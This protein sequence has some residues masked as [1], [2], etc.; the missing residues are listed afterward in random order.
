MQLSMSGNAAKDK[1]SQLEAKRP[2]KSALK[3]LKPDG[4][5]SSSTI[6]DGKKDVDNVDKNSKGPSLILES[7]E[8]PDIKVPPNITCA[9]LMAAVKHQR[10]DT[11]LDTLVFTIRTEIPP[12]ILSN[13]SSSSP[14][15]TQQNNDKEQEKLLTTSP[16]ILSLRDVGN[17]RKDSI[18]EVFNILPL[19]STIEVFSLKG[20]LALLANHLPIVYPDTL[21]QMTIG[22]KFTGHV[23]LV[24][25]DKNF[26]NIHTF[27]FLFYSVTL[28]KQIQIE[29]RGF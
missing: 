19:P 22:S 13:S 6:N 5:T 21:R 25:H 1:R 8:F 29:S 12:L 26:G 11:F 3:K 9:T 28:V 7:E 14:P 24:T 20:G 18:P 4:A 2:V 27:L 15:P 17:K 23:G 16:D 10:P